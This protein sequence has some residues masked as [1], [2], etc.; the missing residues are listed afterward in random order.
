MR[1]NPASPWGE[2]I[3]EEIFI[4]QP[5]EY[6]SLEEDAGHAALWVYPDRKPAE[7]RALM[8]AAGMG[9]AQLTAALD[10]K[11][12]EVTAHATLVSPPA[13]LVLGLAPEVRSTLYAV[14]AEWPANKHMRQPYHLDETDL[15]AR[16][17]AGGVAPETIAL[18][19]KLIYRRQGN[20]YFSDIE[21]VARTLPDNAAKVRLLKVLSGQRAVLAGLRLQ[22]DSDIDKLVGYWGKMPGVHATDIR[23]L[24]ESVARTPGGGTLN[25]LHLLPAFA[26]ER[27]F[28]FP[29]PD[30]PGKPGPDCHW[31]ALNFFNPVPDPRMQDIA[32][33]SAH[34]QGNF[35]QIGVP[36]TIGD[37]IF[38][39]D[40]AGGVIHSAVYIADD[41]VFTKNGINFGQPWIL[42]RMADLLKVYTL[43]KT[44]K[45]QYY[46]RKEA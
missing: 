34:V 11:H 14:M 5:N 42:M 40:E 28:T 21:V 35:T 20:A 36:S 18:L 43:D 39:L 29:L 9:E 1:A 25:I 15:D 38:L 13:D 22:P 19:K 4:E 17:G 33:A 24:L 27:L 31:T 3:T 44:P 37:I 32:Y 23:P 7:V 16:M 41:I 8:A 45:V 26:R 46:R 12:V 2:L 10:P 30:Q 6:V